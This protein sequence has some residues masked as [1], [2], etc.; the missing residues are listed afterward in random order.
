MYKIAIV[1][2]E[3]K[4]ADLLT[5]YLMRYGEEHDC[6]FDVTHYDRA[7]EFLNDCNNNYYIVFMDI[8]L[9]DGNGMDVAKE[10]RLVNKTTMIIF[11][12]NL[13]QYAVKGYQV[14]A[15]DFIVKP[16]SYYNFS[17]NFPSALECIQSNK[18]VDVWIKTKESKICLA[19]SRIIYIEIMEHNLTYHTKDG[20]FT[21]IDS[22]GN[23]ADKLRGAAFAFCN[24]CYLVNLKYVTKV[25]QTQV[26]VNGIALQISRRK[27]T[28]FLKDLNDFLAGGN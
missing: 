9:P 1:E 13:A 2:D 10:M 27:R 19:A 14:R 20:K 21:T 24:R 7:K 11:V 5:R 16:I 4:Q 15:F 12:T 6:S 8:E 18:E 22:I 25:T 28:E 23:V 17:L 26:T 3:K